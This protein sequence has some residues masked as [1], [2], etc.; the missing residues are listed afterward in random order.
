M[1][2]SYLQIQAE[3]GQFAEFSSKNKTT[4]VQDNYVEL[5]FLLGVC[6]GVDWIKQN[7][8]DLKAR[9]KQMETMFKQKDSEMSQK[10]ARRVKL[11]FN[12]PV[13][14]Q[15]EKLHISCPRDSQAIAA[16]DCPWDEKEKIEMK[17]PI[18]DL[19]T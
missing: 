17:Q 16:L 18:I 11:V 8:Y 6:A 4:W 2:T 3:L 15:M 13:S 19:T 7:Q 9:I 1:E 10:I 12:P 5:F 14:E